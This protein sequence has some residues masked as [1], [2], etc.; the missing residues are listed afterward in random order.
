MVSNQRVVDRPGRIAEASSV[1][2]F[3]ETTGAMHPNADGNAALADAMLMDLPPAIA[4][5]M[6]DPG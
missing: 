6:D 1:R 5:L 3:T 4:K 2:E